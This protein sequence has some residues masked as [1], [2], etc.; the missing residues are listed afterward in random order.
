MEKLVKIFDGI[1]RAAIDLPGSK[2]LTNRALILSALCGSTTRL[3]GALFSRDTEIMA[4]CLVKLGC[5]VKLFK[6][7]C[8][9]EISS[10]GGANIANARAD[11]FVGNAGTA[12]RFVTAFAALKIGGEY[13]FDSDKEMYSR[14]IKGLCDALSAQGAQFEFLGRHGC[15][16]FKMKTNGLRGGALK[17]DASASSQILSALLMVAP[18]A[19]CA[20]NIEL[21][22][23]TVSRPFVDMT[24]SL[25]NDFSLSAKEISPNAF[26]V[27]KFAGA[28]QPSVGAD[29]TGN[30]EN[31]K[32]IFTVEPDATA[33]SY[34]AMLPA[35]IGGASL[36][37]NFGAC[38]IQGDAKFVDVLV[39]SGLVDVKKVGDD[40]LVVSKKSASALPKILK[41]V[42]DFNDISD[43]FITFAA[44][45]ML[46]GDT[47][48]IG[49]IAHTRAQETDRVSAV[50]EQLSKFCAQVDEGD[51]F[52]KI[53]PHKSSDFPKKISAPISV[54]TY[55]DHRMAMAFAVPACADIGIGDWL[56]I[57][58]PE[59]VS[60]TWRNFFDVLESARTDSKKFR[61]VAIDGGAAVG[62]SSVSRECSSVLNYMHVD[63][64][65]HY[66]T[67]AFGL[68]GCGID[69]EN[70][71]AVDEHLKT[72]KLGT[73][74]VGN[75]ARITLNDAVVADADIRT[76]RVN[77]NVAKFAAISQVRD[78][79]KNYQRSMADFAKSRG[80]DGLIMEG[81]DIGS[82]IFPNA[83]L[84]IFLDAD[85]ETRAAR[86]AK[87][88]ISDSILKRDAL[89]KSR[90][91]APLVC[92][93][94][95][96][97]IDTSRMTKDEVVAKTLSL[98]LTA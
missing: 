7:E 31:K 90:K 33:A 51:D 30:A 81:R 1:C 59:C 4:D 80:F 69:A 24:L 94:S 63:T 64:G 21:V 43:T 71:S 26:E 68:L 42:F 17:V 65:A 50:A 32:N 83:E 67:V 44:A 52:I 49:G 73:G 29:S 54:S 22:G 40:L 45:A 39:Q 35:I 82:V 9:I 92:P 11:L 58:N 19:D 57:E 84:R 23:G 48:K 60:K 95:A 36:L 15:F 16:P 96:V 12:A 20:M 85:E 87:E 77:E 3:Q 8:A 70:L 62:K 41:T 72:L 34:F 56:K 18:F 47:I 66:R 55:N 74:L 61:V 37:K 14:P 53:Q 76:Q 75:S 97:V 25:M 89:D 86:R 91:T 2:S 93:Q 46:F 27:K 38:K 6:D 98:I 78:F 79:L 10:K 13:F 28:L 5:E 88:G